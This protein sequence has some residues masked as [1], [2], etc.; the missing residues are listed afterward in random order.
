MIDDTAFAAAVAQAQV[1]G[2]VALLTD[3]GGTVYH[4]AFGLA[5]AAAG[6]PMQGDTVFQIA[7][8]TKALVSAA[9]LQLV[10]RGLLSL[11]APIGDLVPELA[12]P[13]VLEG[14]AE[15]GTPQ[16]RPARAVVTLRHLLL[17]TSGCGYAFKDP[18]LLRY[19]VATGTNAPQGT[20]AALDL[21]LLCDPGE[22]WIYGVSTDWVG[23]AIEAATGQSLGE[24]LAAGLT[25]PLG[26]NATAFRNAAAMPED[27]ASVHRRDGAGGFT[28]LPIVLGEGE[29]HSGGGGIS[30]TA[31]DYARFLRMVLNGGVLDGVRVLSPQS[32]ALLA[33]DALPA[34]LSAGVMGTAMP[35]LS[36]A[37][38]PLPGQRGGWT[39]G[40][41]LHNAHDLPDGG[42]SAGSLH[43][44]GI[45]NCYYWID[46]S[47]QRAGLLLTQLAPFADS[48]VLSAFA[49]LQTLAAN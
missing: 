21:P 29:F 36:G 12:A 35:E 3:A 16:L 10:E 24:T 7:S 43:W 17:H 45:F 27:A 37:Y 42:R 23:L 38:D 32:A 5:D 22:R 20:R 11:D 8:M 2:A 44:A 4:R 19:I 13:Q 25:G 6:R 33:A 47:R 15:D 34:H 9:A 28:V 14:F 26:M 41:L 39:L 48:Q 40:G 31:P 30:S 1:P 49:A 18:E 46:P